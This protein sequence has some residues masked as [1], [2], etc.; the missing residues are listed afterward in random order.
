MSN[1]YF[2]EKQYISK[3]FKNRVVDNYVLPKEFH[4]WYNL[5]SF[6]TV[7]NELC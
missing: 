2:L 3:I 1:A 7:L 6:S 5:V 4:F